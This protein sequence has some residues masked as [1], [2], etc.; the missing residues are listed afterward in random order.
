MKKIDY[1]I[2]LVL[3][4]MVILV[5][6]C[7]HLNW[8]M[9][10]CIKSSCILIVIWQSISALF[11]TFKQFKTNIEKEKLKKYWSLVLSQAIVATVYGPTHPIFLALLASA[12]LYYLSF[13]H[14]LVHFKRE[15]ALW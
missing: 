11:H 12:S 1:Y 14:K 10:A 4:G 9:N 2:Q 15:K 8:Q 13:T 5:I 7:I 6:L 3:L